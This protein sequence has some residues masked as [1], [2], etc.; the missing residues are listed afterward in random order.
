MPIAASII[1]MSISRVREYA[2]DEGA[3][4][5]T[6]HPEWLMSALSKLEGYS[7]NYQMNHVSSNTAHMFIINPFGNFAGGLANL[8][9]THP[10][11]N[12]R[13]ARLERIRRGEI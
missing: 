4:R 8:F 9:R 1:Q 10:S 2:A 5:L 12:D 6:G 7:K 3:A 11:T 13:I